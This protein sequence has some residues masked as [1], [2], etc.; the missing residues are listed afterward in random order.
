MP[1]WLQDREPVGKMNPARNEREV[2]VG[3][4]VERRCLDFIRNAVGRKSLDSVQPFL[5]FKLH[6]LK[7][8]KARISF[9]H[10]LSSFIS[11]M[12]PFL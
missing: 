2:H 4:F 3:P 6:S 7:C 5:A 8:G 1:V 9:W 12:P 11:F 10:D